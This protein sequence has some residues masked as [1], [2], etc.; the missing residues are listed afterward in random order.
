MFHEQRDILVVICVVHSLCLAFFAQCKHPWIN[1]MLI[2]F[3]NNYT[4]LARSKNHFAAVIVH[5]CVC[6]NQPTATH[7]D[8][9]QIG[10]VFIVTCLW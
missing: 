4:L 7:W 10:K 6:V 5:V 1:S 9:C 2:I 3:Q 8:N